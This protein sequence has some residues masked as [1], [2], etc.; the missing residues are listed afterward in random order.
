MSKESVRTT[1][2][3]PASLLDAVDR[4]VRG[5][6]T[7][8][9]NAF[10]CAAL[11][12]ELAARERAEIDAAFAHMADDDAYRAEAAALADRFLPADW[13]AL[14]QA[15]HQHADAVDAPR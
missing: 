5:G 12:R 2:T 13:E 11:R 1:L 14:R 15:E 6:H 7:S 8:S 9:R 3:L 4:A 10:I